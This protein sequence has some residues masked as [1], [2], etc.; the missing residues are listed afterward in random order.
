MKTLFATLLLS[1]AAGTALAHGNHDDETFV[2]LKPGAQAK[3][4]PTAAQR[5]ESEKQAKLKAEKKTK[6]QPAKPTTA[7][8]P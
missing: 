4:A 5:A 8:T 1:L 3:P 6:E 7:P 2:P